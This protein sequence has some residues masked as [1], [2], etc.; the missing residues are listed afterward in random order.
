MDG[1]VGLG[2]LIAGQHIDHSDLAAELHK[3][4]GGLEAGDAGA[5]DDYVV[6]DLSGTAVDVVDEDDAA[7]ILAG[8]PLGEE[9]DVADGDDG[10]VEALGV[11]QLGGSLGAHADSQ[12]LLLVG[13]ADDVAQ[14]ALQVIL[15]GGCSGA[16]EHAAEEVA[17]LEEGDIVT[18]LG[19]DTGGLYAGRAARR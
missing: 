10:G 7:L 4:I 11:E 6:A 16:A 17:L 5:D 15:E 18:A 1:G 13:L 9:G 14:V 12:V 19:S 3:A 2:Y 8:E